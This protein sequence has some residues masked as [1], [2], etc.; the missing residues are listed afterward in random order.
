MI[1][2]IWRIWEDWPTRLWESTTGVAD[3]SIHYIDGRE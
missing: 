3:T 2:R 1:R